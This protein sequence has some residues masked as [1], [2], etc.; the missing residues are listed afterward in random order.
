MY[1]TIS[2]EGLS[3]T[4][5][6]DDARFAYH[7]LLRNARTLSIS[8][9]LETLAFRAAGAYFTALTRPAP[10]TWSAF[11][12]NT[13]LFV[14]H[15]A[16]LDGIVAFDI[17]ERKALAFFEA[18]VRENADLLRVPFAVASAANR[19]HGRYVPA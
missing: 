19:E 17:E 9:S 14:Q 12:E 1:C 11:V 13:V 18:I 2:A 8:R 3:T 15:A 4:E 7:A 10:A 5:L 16:S 6:D